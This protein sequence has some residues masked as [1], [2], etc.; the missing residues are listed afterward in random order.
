RAGA[1]PRRS[2]WLTCRT[3]LAKSGRHQATRSDCVEAARPPEL[4][5][6]QT[7]D[8]GRSAP[9]WA[10]PMPKDLNSDLLIA[11]EAPA[12]ARE[13]EALVDRAFGPGRYAK[14]AERLREGNHVLRELSVVA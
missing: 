11:P 4:S 10:P 7:I 8:A 9:Y 3:V 13:A 6:H 1:G 5:S 14:S 12:D 2:C